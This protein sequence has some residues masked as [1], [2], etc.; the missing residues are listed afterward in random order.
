MNSKSPKDSSPKSGMARLIELATTKKIPIILA[1][2][3]SALASIASF[4][5]YI[6]IYYAIRNIIEVYPD[7]AELNVQ[8]T[9]GYGWIAFGGVIVN[10]LLYFGALMCSHIA[11]FG[12]LY[13]LKINFADHIG[14]LPLGF[15]FNYGSGK[16]RKIMEENIE[17]LEGFIA[18]QLPDIVASIV[19]TVTMFVIL[20]VFDWRF[21][22]AAMIG[23]IIA[24]IVEFTAYGNKTA[25]T[26]MGNYQTTLENMNNTSVEYVRGITVVKAFRQTVYSFGRL[27]ETIKAYMDNIIPFSMVWR[28]YFCGFTTIINN[29]Y[30]FLIPVGIL[31]GLKT[32]DYVSYAMAFIFYLLFVPSVSTVM[33]KIMYVSSGAMDISGGIGRMD[34]VLAEDILPETEH[35]KTCEG[36]DIRFDNVS[37][38]YDSVQNIAAL[39]NVSF[40]AAQGEI[41]AIVG[42]SGSGKST[43]ANMLPR[44]YD[45]TSGSICIGGVD[46][47]E[48]SFSYLMN[49]VSFV[50][51]DIFL[52]RQSI[53]KNISTG[54]PNVT[55]QQVI[56]AA[57]A[58]QCHQFISNLPDGYDTV[59]GT[60][61]IH[62]SGGERQ[63]IAIAR[64]IVKDAPILILD[65]ATAFADPENENLI[66]K[67][68]E[69]LIVNKTVL[70]IA[71][72]LSTIRSANKIIVMNKGEIVE[73]GTHE[74][75]LVLEGKYKS[76]WE[77][78]TKSLD[79]KMTAGRKVKTNV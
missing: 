33:T 77:T 39:N 38:Y 71:H 11:A 29:I 25:K 22:A 42:P 2:V 8:Q 1:A 44:F 41:T 59:V 60:K 17:K 16:L 47:R 21:G 43:I 79:W 19:A 78:F 66:Q 58:A 46:I 69:K 23:I 52:F 76:M 64:A 30:L 9:I 48:M 49:K 55:K 20:L 72:R 14:R 51:Q 67:A 45:V 70:I 50:F 36:C 57:K 13:D 40:Q 18:H 35:P 68:F 5:P 28:N 15:H 61:G 24:F 53:F 27:R 73:Q 26:V 6:A 34:G 75:L 32:D 10:I 7:I 74:H 54:D 31:I 63:R 56:E 12:T 3:L 65:E 62:L 37:F 4:V